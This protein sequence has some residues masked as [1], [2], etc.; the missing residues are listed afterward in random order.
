MSPVPSRS[1]FSCKVSKKRQDDVLNTIR[2]QRFCD[3]TMTTSGLG[4]N[5]SGTQGY[6]SFLKMVSTNGEALRGP[7]LKAVLRASR[8]FFRFEGSKSINK[9][10]KLSHYH[11]QFYDSTANGTESAKFQTKFVGPACKLDPHFAHPPSPKR[12]S[13]LDAECGVIQAPCFELQRSAQML[14]VNRKLMRRI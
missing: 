8:R 4:D 12:S 3:I 14:R 1:K 5:N 10:S 9:T 11:W 2:Q 7:G 6:L 13:L